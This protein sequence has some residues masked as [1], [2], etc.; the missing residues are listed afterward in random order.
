MSL[1]K[2]LLI[3]NL[4]QDPSVRFL[5]NNK[6]VA[7]FTLATNETYTDRNGERRTETEWHTIE[8]W[9]QLARN[10]DN[11]KQKGYLKKGTQVYV[12][13]KI[14]TENYKDKDGNDR[15]GKKIR[16]LT[17]TLLGSSNKNSGESGEGGY[18]QPEA[19]QTNPAPTPITN[20]ATPPVS[21]PNPAPDDDLPF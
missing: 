5:D 4:G 7:S 6:V 13:G 12:E 1:N 9:D 11:L 10:V 19:Q 8:M 14:R 3:G 18:R 17:L 15:V 16:A 21:A 20:Y 2:V